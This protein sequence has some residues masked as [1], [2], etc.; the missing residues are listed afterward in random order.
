MWGRILSEVHEILTV[1][2]VGPSDCVMPHCPLSHYCT[3]K[4]SLSNAILYLNVLYYKDAFNC[5]NSC[6]DFIIE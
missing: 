6:S 2:V 5:F 4:E 1:G 3:A